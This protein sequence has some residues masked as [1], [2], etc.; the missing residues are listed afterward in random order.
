MLTVWAKYYGGHR[1]GGGSS[2]PTRST[3]SWK[4]RLPVGFLGQLQAQP[5][6][7]WAS[8]HRDGK[9]FAPGQPTN[10]LGEINQLSETL[11]PQTGRPSLAT[12]HKMGTCVLTR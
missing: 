12:F 2:V 9:M 1:E 5:S 7:P 4:T 3:G 8:R 6:G 10:G 11:K